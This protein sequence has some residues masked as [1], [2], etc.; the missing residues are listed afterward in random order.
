LARLRRIRL[1]IWMIAWV[2]TLGFAARAWAGSVEAPT[3]HRDV[4]P[5]VYAN[6][7][8][9]HRTGQTGPFELM[10]YDDVRKR[11][12]EIVKV[13]GD[14]T[15]PPWKA[16]PPV[17][18]HPRFLGD[19]RLADE[20]IA[21]LRAWAESGCPEG[22]PKDAKPTPSFV[23]G[24]RLGEPDLVVTMPEPYTLAAEGRDVYRAFRVPITVPN[25]TYITA[26][27]VR[28]GNRKIVHHVV[29]TTLAT[30]EVEKLEA[31][32]PKGTGPGFMTG[33]S[34][35][36]ERLPGQMGIWVPGI[37]PLALPDGYQMPWPNG[38]EFLIQLHLHP[39]GKAEQEQT[40]IGFHFTDKPPTDRLRALILLNKDLDIPPG[41]K[42]YTL[43]ASRTLER[44]IDIVGMFPHMHLLGRTVLA[45]ATFPDGRSTPLLSIRDWDFAW[46]GY[47]QFTTPLRLPAGT[48]VD[49]VFTFDNSA[50]NPSNPSVPPRRV[51]F[52][53]QTVDEMGA[54]LFD[55]I[56]RGRGRQGD[57]VKG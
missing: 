7:T 13:V 49:A 10:T 55:V 12:K 15:M 25:G 11:A 19:R 37:D 51:R 4:A 22:D 9:C 52:G 42:Q 3:F 56:E 35:P 20:Q 23:D 5:L 26:A 31:K 48:R 45:T 36:G 24:W 47:Y 14:R 30:K 41:D 16:E 21:M 18:E 54:V 39:S 34:A 33:L 8:T 32:E 44:D 57:K 28:P 2:A 27:E 17:A 1:E 53:E 46:Q 43:N 6:C 40:S 50:E 29:L 38:R